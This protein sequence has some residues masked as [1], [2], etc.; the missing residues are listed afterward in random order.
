M[1]GKEVH[2]GSIDCYRGQNAKSEYSCENW[3]ENSISEEQKFRNCAVYKWASL[4]IS[5]EMCKGSLMGQTLTWMTLEKPVSSF[6]RKVRLHI[7]L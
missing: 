7:S 3:L 5:L 6:W 1:G 2:F 4:A